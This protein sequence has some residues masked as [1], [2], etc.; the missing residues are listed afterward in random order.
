M[1]IEIN[2]QHRRIRLVT[3]NKACW[4]TK[5]PDSPVPLRA[6]NGTLC[7]WQRRKAADTCSVVSSNT[8]S[9]GQW[10]KVNRHSRN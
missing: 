5:P 6:T 3:T 2:L 10:L 4:S 7:W 8:A 9:G 1:V